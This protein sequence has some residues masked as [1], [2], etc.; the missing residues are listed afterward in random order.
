MEK[1][2]ILLYV[3]L[4]SVILLPFILST[5]NIFKKRNIANSQK[6]LRNKKFNV[7]HVDDPE[8]KIPKKIFQCFKTR[9]MVPD[10]VIDNI[11]NLNPQ[12]EYHFYDDNMCIQ[13]LNDHYGKEYV[14]KFNGFKKGA[15][16]ADLWRYCVLYMYGGVYIDIDLEMLVPLDAII[17]NETFIV[18]YTNTIPTKIVNANNIYNA[19]IMVKPKHPVIYDCIQRIM[20]TSFEHAE[21]DYLV[22]VRQMKHAVK[23][24]LKVKKIKTMNYIDERTKIMHEYWAK[25]PFEWKVYDYTLNKIIANSKYSNYSRTETN[26]QFT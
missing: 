17:D 9:N 6:K 3:L 19:L 2:F 20:K 12:W 26:G 13:F 4:F 15:H 25:L 24:F 7:P 22:N 16:K 5:Y 23:K 11:K 10:K 21:H 14:D 8:E 18:P 1:S